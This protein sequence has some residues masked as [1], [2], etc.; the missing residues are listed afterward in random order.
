ME[1]CCGTPDGMGVTPAGGASPIRSC[2][3]YV[4]HGCHGAQSTAQI[5]KDGRSVIMRFRSVRYLIESVF[6]EGTEDRVQSA[7]YGDYSIDYSPLAEKWII[8]KNLE[9][10]DQFDQVEDAIEEA[11]RLS[12]KTQEK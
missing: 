10:V 3:S 8:R 6:H 9:F 1:Q 7:Y 5:E 12:G 2:G 11:K 4:T